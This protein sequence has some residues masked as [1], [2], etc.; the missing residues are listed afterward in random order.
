MKVASK[1]NLRTV[2]NIEKEDKSECPL[3][4]IHMD[5]RAMM[6]R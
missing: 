4:A 3:T 5:C 1:A 2:Q 6:R